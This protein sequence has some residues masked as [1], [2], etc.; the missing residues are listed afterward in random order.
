VGRGGEVVWS[1]CG[2][3]IRQLSMAIYKNSAN[4]NL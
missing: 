3:F 2:S 1:L 4:L